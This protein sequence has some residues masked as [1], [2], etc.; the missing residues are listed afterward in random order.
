MA[1]IIREATNTFYVGQSVSV[2]NGSTLPTYGSVEGGDK[3]FAMMLEG[4]R[5]MCS[6]HLKKTQA[7]VSATRRIE[8]LSFYGVKADASQPLQFP[9][10]TDTT[11]PVEIEQAT[12]ELAQVLLKGVNPDIEA[13]NL[14]V[15]TQAFAQIRSQFDRAF[16]PPYVRAGIPSQTAWNLLMPFLRPQLGVTLVRVD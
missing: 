8:T 11:V 3:Y 13:D 9:R 12:Y 2:A 14:S 1:T 10:G 5:W 15:T 4:Q 7:L 16:V 6:T